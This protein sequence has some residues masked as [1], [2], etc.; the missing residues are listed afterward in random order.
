MRLELQ[1]HGAIDASSSPPHTSTTD[2]AQ[3]RSA[4][5]AVYDR[6]VAP[7]QNTP[8]HC[9]SPRHADHTTRSPSRTVS[10][11]PSLSNRA[12]TSP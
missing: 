1:F 12:S 9:T 8:R 6:T 5:C 4:R 7:S 11:L 2:P 3:P 10:R